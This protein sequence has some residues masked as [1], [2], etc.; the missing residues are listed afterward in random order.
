MVNTHVILFASPNF[1]YTTN[2]L[3][4]LMFEILL[5]S[6]YHKRLHI[7]RAAL[8]HLVYAG[9]VQQLLAVLFF[10]LL[11]FL[12]FL[13]RLFFTE[14]LSHLRFLNIRLVF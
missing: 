10:L 12:T 7:N 11:I 1:H 13:L 14:F 2:R 3:G 8:L 6:D 9:C 5:F 4:L